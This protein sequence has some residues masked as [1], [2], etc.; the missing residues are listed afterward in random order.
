MRNYPI[1]L[2]LILIV[3]GQGAQVVIAVECPEL[4]SSLKEELFEKTDYKY[5]IASL[6]TFTKDIQEKILIKTDNHCPQTV[7]IHDSSVFGILLQAQGKKGVIYHAFYA[8]ANECCGWRIWKI[9]KFVNEVPLIKP[10]E[11]GIYLDLLTN[12]KINILPYSSAVSIELLNSGEEY[13]YK[14]DKR[15]KNK[16]IKY[17]LKQNLTSLDDE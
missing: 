1:L 12:K 10:I 14:K 2:L 7:L 5:E 4:P 16:A 3:F 6:N 8:S 15:E 17:K 9:D 13:V 11:E